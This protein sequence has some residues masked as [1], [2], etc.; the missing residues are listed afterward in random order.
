MLTVAGCS[1]SLGMQIMHNLLCVC[2]PLQL[3]A[4]MQWLR[5]VY[6][7]VD[8]QHA[9]FPKAVLSTLAGEGIAGLHAGASPSHNR[10]SLGFSSFHRACPS[11]ISSCLL[12]PMPVCVCI[13]NMIPFLCA[14]LAVHVLHTL[15]LQHGTRCA[16]LAAQALH[17]KHGRPSWWTMKK[18]CSGGGSQSRE[19][20]YTR[21]CTFRTA[22]LVQASRFH[23]PC[24]CRAV[25]C[26]AA[27]CMVWRD[28]DA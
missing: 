14:S 3:C 1:K 2:Q 18:G 25:S 20:T 7:L 27:S 22:P 17:K 28:H 24:M 10:S 11:I 13:P 9:D 23:S 16:T 19:G 4:R 21:P 5:R 15:R 8:H 26:A 6:Q 12:S